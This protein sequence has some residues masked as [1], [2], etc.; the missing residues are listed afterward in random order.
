VRPWV[1]SEQ[2]RREH[3]GGVLGC[4]RCSMPELPANVA[5]YKRVG[6]FT[7]TTIPAGLLRRHTLK[8]AVWGRIEV[9][10]G[11][12]RYVIERDP[13]VRFVLAPSIP[14][15]VMPEEPHRV[16]ACGPVRFQIE[17]LR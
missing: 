12:L 7:E 3:L 10:E 2:G 6:P 5:P 16:E 17:F 15:I 13:D 14:G 8:P 4:V 9:L 11:E 1:L